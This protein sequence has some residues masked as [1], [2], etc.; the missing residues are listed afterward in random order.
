LR[1]VDALQARIEELEAELESQR[2]AARELAEVRWKLDLILSAFP[3]V[4]WTIRADGEIALVEGEHGL[5][6]MGMRPNQT[7]GAS[8][9]L[10]YAEAPEVLSNIERGLLGEAFSA[11]N[12]I[13]GTRFENHYFPQ[14]AAEGPPYELRGLTW[15]ANL[16]EDIAAE[17][18]QAEL[19]VQHK[20]KQESLAVLAG[21]IAHDF[22]N[23][24]LGSLGHADLALRL[25]DEGSAM[26]GHLREIVRSSERAAD[27][28]HQLLAY[29]GRG[30][31]IVKPE[32]LNRVV[33]DS[34]HLIELTIAKTSVLHAELTPALPPFRGDATQ[35]VQV[36]INLMKNASDAASGIISVRTG[37]RYLEPD[38]L[39][40]TVVAPDS[41]P[42]EYVFVAVEDQG[43][44]MR[45]E[46]IGRIFDPFY[47]TKQTGRGLGL[48][49]VIGI[50][51]S[52]G[53]MLEVE[54]DV[55]VGTTMVVYLP[56]LGGAAQS[57]QQPPRTPSSRPVSA[58]VLVVDD[59]PGPRLVAAAM[60][61][62]SGYKVLEAANGREAVDLYRAQHS[63]IDAVL[64]D[65]SMPVMNGATALRELRAID[66]EAKVILVSG[67][68][69]C[70]TTS[71]LAGLRPTAF[72]LKPYRF[73][74]L[75]DVFGSAFAP[76]RE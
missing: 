1:D 49:A 53:G 8:V 37:K 41:K 57:A 27:L 7:V 35:I 69:E 71:Q 24:L 16:H 73:D 43:V 5:S 33:E 64:M 61:E 6:L 38:E 50:V 14:R 21:G 51:R 40:M 29:A 30:Q 12:E 56:A 19:E 31:F 11:S 59:E 4:V 46:E 58:T 63:V 23:L 18:Q 47:S 15:I 32:D 17:R 72:L 20:Q 22:N 65:L 36:L 42:G 3:V 25:V 44:G 67:Y 75:L 26:A 60:L 54:S 34:M 48:A 76:K 70:D 62:Q 52:H 68:A 55:G 28:C 10:V 39:R 66:P 13:A 9:R 74:Q 45:P 2:R